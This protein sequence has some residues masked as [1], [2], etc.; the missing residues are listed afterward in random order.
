MTSRQTIA[1]ILTTTAIAFSICTPARAAS[2][3]GGMPEGSKLHADR[4]NG[5]SPE[6][7]ANRTDTGARAQR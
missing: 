6:A 2:L 1:A 7:G 4:C 3:A 5:Q